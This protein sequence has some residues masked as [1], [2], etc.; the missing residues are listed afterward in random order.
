[1]HIRKASGLLWPCLVLLALNS[2]LYAEPVVYPFIG[3]MDPAQGTIEMWMAPR[4]DP[5]APPTDQN[6]FIRNI[7]RVSQDDNN[8]FQILWRHVTDHSTFPDA[9]PLGGPWVR[10]AR[11]GERVFVSMLIW[12]DT[13]RIQGA[14]NDPGTW[15][16]GEL[17]HVAYC[18]DGAQIW[19]YIDGQEV[20]RIPMSGALGLR[21]SEDLIIEIGDRRTDG[22]YIRDL[23]ISSLPRRPAELGY[24]QPDGMRADL[25]TL[26]L[27]RATP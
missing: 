20:R 11:Q 5:V 27:H 16:K 26:L 13:A 25:F 23:R 9:G 19:L 4:F 2:A 7:L 17:R 10:A 21:S 15:A 22:I 1:M 8:Y 3:H 6:V 24:H 12:P 14:W 18:W